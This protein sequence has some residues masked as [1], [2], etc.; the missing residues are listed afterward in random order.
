MLTD[1]YDG[2]ISGSFSNP[3]ANLN[4]WC[5]NNPQPYLNSIVDVSAYAGQTVQFRFRLGTDTSANRPGWNIDDV[6]VQ[7]CQ[8]ATPPSFTSVTATPSAINENNGITLTGTFTNPN[9]PGNHTLLVSW[10]DGL[11]ETLPTLGPGVYA[12]NATHQYLDDN[13]TGTPADLNSINL[14][15][16]DSLGSNVV[17]TTNVTVSNVAPVVNA[18]TDQSVQVGTA[19]QAH[20]RVRRSWNA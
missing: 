20:R 8:A 11:T 12:F 9:P 13:P 4:A 16:S 18:G 6:V 5:G 19:V 7:S 2:P 17:T 15:L 10:G 3:L 1:P 14:T